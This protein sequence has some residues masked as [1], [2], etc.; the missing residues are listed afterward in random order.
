MRRS[1]GLVLALAAACT[2]ADPDNDLPTDTDSDSDSDSVIPSP[3]TESAGTVTPLLTDGP[4]S[5]TE[6]L[7]LDPAGPVY[8]V[9]DDHLWKIDGGE[10]EQILLTP[11]GVGATWWNDAIWVA[12]W[13][14]GVG[15]PKP[16]IYEVQPDG[17]GKRYDTPTIAKPNFLLPT[18]WGTLLISDDFD[19]R[20]FEWD[21]GEVSVWASGI[22]S[23][24][25]MGFSPDGKTLWVASTFTNPGLVAIT[26]DGEK[27]GA[28]EKVVAFDPGTTP[29]G[30]AVAN[31]GA[32]YVA[33][34]L[35]G[36]IDVWDGEAVHTL[37]DGTIPTPASL[38]FGLGAVDTCTLVVTS[39]FGDDV[40]TVTAEFDGA[41]VPR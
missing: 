2:A 21:A 36:R 37:T 4:W 29:D 13:E 39:L 32:V 22:S 40:W 26:L 33:L 17:Q 7:A 27:A 35:A 11:R 14:D 19:T 30:L 28:S 38:S 6:G 16:A 9:G 41:P 10:A 25:G 31:N 15:D 20:I 3:C 24:N 12:V 1:T 34:N 5:G 18:P 8:V 23:P